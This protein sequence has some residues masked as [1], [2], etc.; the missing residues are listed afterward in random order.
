MKLCYKISPLFVSLSSRCQMFGQRS[1]DFC[2][3]GKTQQVMHN[4]AP[5]G[6]HN[7]YTHAHTY[8]RKQ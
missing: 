6:N 4:L 5:P 2:W 3:N 7:Q 8:T 1:L